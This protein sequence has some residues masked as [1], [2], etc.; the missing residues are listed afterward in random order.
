MTG[1]LAA[2][3]GLRGRAPSVAPEAVPWPVPSARLAARAFLYIFTVRLTI[4]LRAAGPAF[5]A[6]RR[7]P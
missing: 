4:I 3:G 2:S 1:T 7:F 6:P 5:H